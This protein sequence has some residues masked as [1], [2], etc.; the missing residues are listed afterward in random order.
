MRGLPWGATLLA[1]LAVAAPALAAD[2]APF[3][4]APPI[5]ASSWTGFYAG[6]GLGLRATQADLTTTLAERNGFSFDPNSAVNTQPVNGT[7]FRAN[8]YAGYNWQVTPSWVFGVEGD[9]GFGDQTTTLRGFTYGP[10]FG[11]ST[12]NA[13]GL[14]VKTTWDASLR[15][16]AGYLLTP[17][18]LVYATGG[19]AWQHYDITSTCVSV[20]CDGATPA[21]V[22][23]ST[24][25][26]GWTLGGG[27]ETALD[28]NWLLRS[29]YR[30]ADFGT[31]SFS[32]TRATA[33][34]LT[35]ENFDTKLATHTA[36]VGVAYK[37]GDPGL[38]GRSHPLSAQAAMPSSWTGAYAGLGLGARA[39]RTDLIATSETVGGF[40]FDLTERANTRPFD[41]TAFRA[42][43]YAGY[44]WQFAPQWTAGIEGDFGFADS[45]TTRGGFTSIFLADSQ[46]PGESLSIRSKWD[47][48]LRARLGYLVSPQTMLY[49]TAGVAWQ[50]VELTSTCVSVSCNGFFGV[51]PGIVSASTTK[52]GWTVGGGLETVLWGNWLA[53]AEYRYAD[54]GK[55]SFTVARSSTNPDFNPSINTWDVAMRTHL[56]TFGVTYRFE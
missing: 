41:N 28:G 25:R 13:D 20:V 7:G 1:G 18:T 48:S 17:A 42:S 19:L 8:P 46:E 50:N 39:A 47:A 36:T 22:S 29:E 26:T 3:T 32:I 11:S 15:G 23:N 9:V 24:T 54:Y 21:V 53:R 49:A 30:Y 38:G 6:L 31:A 16:R 12:F 27:V 5:V 44:L 43:P 55:A 33:F 45:T 10:L 35:I 52:A 34:G 40:P 56:A 51:S 4:K 2:L 37:F 14:S